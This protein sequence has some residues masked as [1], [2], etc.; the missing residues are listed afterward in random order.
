MAPGCVSSSK[1]CFVFDLVNILKFKMWKG[2]GGVPF[3]RCFGRLQ[4]QNSVYIIYI[5]SSPNLEKSVQF[6]VGFR[7]NSLS[8]QLLKM[9]FDHIINHGSPHKQDKFGHSGHQR[10]IETLQIL[11]VSHS[12]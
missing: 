7:F 8:Q 1:N 3:F 4:K 9:T 5:Y 12:D 2:G 10:E 11:L 6:G